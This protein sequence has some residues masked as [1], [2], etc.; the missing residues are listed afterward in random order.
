MGIEAKRIEPMADIRKLNDGP[1]RSAFVEGAARLDSI[2]RP[3]GQNGEAPAPLQAAADRMAAISP[4]EAWSKRFM[5]Q[6]IGPGK[7]GPEPAVSIPDLALMESAPP[8]PEPPLR[9]E[10][11]KPGKPLPIGAA[12]GKPMRRSWLGRLIRGR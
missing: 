5:S 1:R 6:G 11:S 10:F 3:G 2:A 12:I 4:D 7:N 8:K 9:R